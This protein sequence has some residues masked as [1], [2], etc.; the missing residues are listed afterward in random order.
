MKIFKSLLLAFA[1]SF[2]SPGFAKQQEIKA[3]GY[4]YL[5]DVF[6]RPLGF[7]EIIAG[8]ATFVV[9]SPLTAI[10]SIPAP[11][12]NAF[13]ELADSLVVKPVKFT[14]VR[15]VGDYTFMGGQEK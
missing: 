4:D 15:P 1:V 3:D 5:I 13:A 8:T 12:E 10:A 11:K 2:A 9:L 14:F 6:L 7:V